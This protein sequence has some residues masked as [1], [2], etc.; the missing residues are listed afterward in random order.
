MPKYQL[1]IQADARFQPE[2]SDPEN[3]HYVFTYRVSITNVGSINTQIVARQWILE[4]EKGGVYPSKGRGI[5][6]QQPVLRP[7]QTFQYESTCTITTPG[8]MLRGNYLCVADDGTVFPSPIAPF[9]LDSGKAR[10][11]GGEGS[12]SHNGST[13]LLH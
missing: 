1:H 10:S 2:K 12:L 6:N 8:G 9:L 3:N 13:P 5:V 7:R 4:D 11:N